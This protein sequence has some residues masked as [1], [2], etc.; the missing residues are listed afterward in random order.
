[1]KIRLQPDCG[2]IGVQRAAQIAGHRAGAPEVIVR[3]GV[4]RQQ[5]DRAI[6][7]LDRSAGVRAPQGGER[8]GVQSLN[9][10]RRTLQDL[11]EQLLCLGD[12]PLAQQSFGLSGGGHNLTLL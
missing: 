7:Q 9:I 6:E 10:V 4:V 5:R 1:M 11:I 12:A 8:N 2:G 3:Q